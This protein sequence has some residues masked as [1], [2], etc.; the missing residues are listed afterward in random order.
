M[1]YYPTKRADWR[2]LREQLIGKNKPGR[3]LIS[4]HDIDRVNLNYARCSTHRDPPWY[5]KA[6]SEYV[7]EVEK[8]IRL[9]K[10]VRNEHWERTGLV[11]IQYVP[12]GEQPFRIFTMNTNK[13]TT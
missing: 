11:T 10:S 13:E 7:V 12:A 2:W 5:M 3:I 4:G 1:T 6:T 9:G 8:P